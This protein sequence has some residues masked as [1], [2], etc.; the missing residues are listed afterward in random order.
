MTEYARNG[1]AVVKR[2]PGGDWQPAT[3]EEAAVRCINLMDICDVDTL[4]G[5]VSTSPRLVR[6]KLD[7][8]TIITG[9]LVE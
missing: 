2:E 9:E 8:G 6:V 1:L 3:P 7:D 4:G 5:P